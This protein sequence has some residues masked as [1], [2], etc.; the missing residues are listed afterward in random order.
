[1]KKTQTRWSDL[2]VP[3]PK[4]REAFSYIGKKSRILYGGAR[5]GAKTSFSVWAAVSSCLQYPG[6]RVGIVRKIHKELQAQIIDNELLKHFPESKVPYK[7]YKGAKVAE[8]KNGSRIY[9]ISLQDP[10]D[11]EKEQGIERGLY[12]LDEGNKLPWDSIVKLMGSNRSGSGI[13]NAKGEPWKDTMI[14]TAN[15]GGV[16][17]NEIKNRWVKPDYSKWTKAELKL[18]DEYV[19]IKANVFD[20]KHVKKDYAE[21]LA[22]LP[23][24]LKRMWLDGDWDVNTGAFFE[25]WN[26]GVHVVDALPNGMQRPPSDWAKWRSVDM[27]GGT[28]PS[29]CLWNCQDPDTGDIYTYNEL[30]SLNVTGVFIDGVIEESQGEE[31]MTGY[32]DPAMFNTGNNHIMDESPGMMFLKRGIWLQPAN[33]K[34]E[35]GWRNL[36]QWLHWTVLQPPKLKVLRRCVKLIETIPIQQYVENKYDLNTRGE[37]D[38]VDAWRYGISSLDFGYVYNRAGCLVQIADTAI[39]TRADEDK[40]GRYAGLPEPT[41]PRF[42]SSMDRK[43][44]IPGHEKSGIKTSIYS[45]F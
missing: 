25:S 38:Y 40:D 19:F 17:D 13:V 14:I 15:P 43:Y 9:M 41:Q 37:D 4:Q 10:K 18:K 29:V 8:F 39:L 12:I 7:Y 31:Y 28:H 42:S 24:Y 3:Q 16:C 26:E 30:G 21:M 22:G 2:Y 36:K 5:G 20:N 27:G 35:I 45:L 23:D 33:N 32:G 34:R 6:L 44:L 1:M 11:I